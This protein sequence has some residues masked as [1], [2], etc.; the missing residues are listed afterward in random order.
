MAVEMIN[1]HLISFQYNKRDKCKSY[2]L[3]H[4]TTHNK[5]NIFEM[6]LSDN[7]QYIMLVCWVPRTNTHPPSVW[8]S[9]YYFFFTISCKILCKTDFNLFFY[10]KIKS[11]ECPKSIRNY[12][13][14]NAW[15]IRR[16][17]DESFLPGN[18]GPSVLYWRL[19]D[20]LKSF[21]TSHLQVMDLLE[22]LL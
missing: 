2:I 21:W 13:K 16:L 20:L 1:I 18:Q 22:P 9:K 17:V 10:D 3:F 14:N 12:E 8:C 7:L 15:N 11:F 19:S 6:M 4:V 5:Q